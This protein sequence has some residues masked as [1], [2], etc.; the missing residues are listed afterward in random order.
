MNAQK[1]KRMDEIISS[2]GIADPT[3][4]DPVNISKLL[5][6]FCIHWFTP[7]NSFFFLLFLDN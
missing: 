7:S 2:P 3:E 1:L 5:T 6:I 4:F